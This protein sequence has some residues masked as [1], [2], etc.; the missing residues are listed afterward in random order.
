[1]TARLHDVSDP[2]TWGPA[3]DDA[4]QTLARGELVVLPTDTVYGIAADAFTPP[5]VQ[6]LLDA[7]GRGRQMPPPVLVGSLPVLD[8]LATAVP[9]GARA[10]AEAF[11]PGGLTLILAAQPSLAWDLGETHGTV[12]LRMP[13]H[14]AALALLRRTGPLAV[15]SANRTG[16]P[17]GTTAAEAREQLGDSVRVYLEAGAAPGGVASTIV[18]AT[19]PVLRVVREG[20]LGLEAL[21]AVTPVEG[22]DE[23]VP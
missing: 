1:M 6:A 16:Q 13:D 12:A 19:G 21:R 20:A 22:R 3:L 11:W 14:P 18:D 5:A 2:T 8:G 9:D 23:A 17:A 7:K 15:S 4:V 10:L